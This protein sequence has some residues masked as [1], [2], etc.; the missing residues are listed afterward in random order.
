[1]NYGG[2]LGIG[3][4]GSYSDP[5]KVIGLAAAVT[6]AAGQNHT[7]AIDLAG[8]VKCWGSNESGE[9]G[10][11]NAFKVSPVLVLGFGKL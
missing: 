10:D 4:A 8:A 9:L 2:Q 7:C 11:G 1:M 5:V 3:Q 6:V